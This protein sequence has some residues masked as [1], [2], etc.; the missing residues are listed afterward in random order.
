MKPDSNELTSGE[1]L[2]ALLERIDTEI[3]Q[4][5]R[6]GKLSLLNYGLPIQDDEKAN[7]TA[8]LKALLSTRQ[9][10]RELLAQSG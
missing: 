9:H 10:Y 7:R 4:L 8:N 1:S 3:H 6:D 2:A 5:L